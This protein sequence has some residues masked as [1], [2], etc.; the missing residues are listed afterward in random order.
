MLAKPFSSEDKPCSE[1]VNEITLQTQILML[2]GKSMS[3]GDFTYAVEDNF[4][5]IH[6]KLSDGILYTISAQLE[7]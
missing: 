1:L 3:L 6:F 4:V 2:T 7:D 5:P